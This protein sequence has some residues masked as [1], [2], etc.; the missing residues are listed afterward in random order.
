MKL[1]ALVHSLLPALLAIVAGCSVLRLDQGGP[2]PGE[3]CPR[4]A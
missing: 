2:V 1:K 3:S 4:R